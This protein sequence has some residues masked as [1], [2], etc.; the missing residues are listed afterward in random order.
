MKWYRIRLW[1]GEPDTGFLLMRNVVEATCQMQAINKAVKP[2]VALL[3][4]KWD[5]FSFKVE[6]IQ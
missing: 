5:E 1:Y 4:P 6:Q 2:I 3:E